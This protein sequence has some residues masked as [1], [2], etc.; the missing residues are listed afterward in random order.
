MGSTIV[1]VVVDG[2]DYE[3]AW[4]GDSRAYLWDGQL[5]Q[6]TQDHSYVRSLVDSG[7]ITPGEALTHPSRHLLIRC[8]GIDDDGQP[9]Q[10]EIR[11]GRFSGDRKYCFVATGLPANSETKG[12]KKLLPRRRPRKKEPTGW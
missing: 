3:V 10:V 5:M 7:A 6:I 9:L 2:I 11:N 1:A 12:L 4:V 8:L